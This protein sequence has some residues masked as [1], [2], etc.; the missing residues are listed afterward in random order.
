MVP[1]LK[2]CFKSSILLSKKKKFQEEIWHLASMSI[3]GVSWV[4][5]EFV[6]GLR[7]AMTGYGSTGHSVPLQLR[8]FYM[9]ELLHGCGGPSR[10]KVTCVLYIRLPKSAPKWTMEL[11]LSR[12]AVNFRGTLQ[13]SDLWL[14]T[15]QG[16]LG[17]TC[18]VLPEPSVK[19]SYRLE[20]N[21]MLRAA[22]PRRAYREETELYKVERN[23]TDVA[24]PWNDHSP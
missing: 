22:K 4:C 8:P 23:H 20:A 9:S 21:R 19:H 3:A 24:Q 5:L 6:W 14:Q 18:R 12:Q 13:W 2:K 11:I 1:F 7:F 17:A 15:P 16:P 10:D